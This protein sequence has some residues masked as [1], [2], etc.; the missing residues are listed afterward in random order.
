MNQGKHLFFK[1]QA[2]IPSEFGIAYGNF[3][4]YLKSKSE[5]GKLPLLSQ[6]F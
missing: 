6:S 3:F 5:V 2:K 1:P 4:A